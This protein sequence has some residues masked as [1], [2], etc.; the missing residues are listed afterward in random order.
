M[1]FKSRPSVSKRTGQTPFPFRAME[2]ECPCTAFPSKFYGLPYPEKLPEC[3]KTDHRFLSGAT[4]YTRESISI[5][6]V[7]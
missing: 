3:L 6:P 1:V 4:D 5:G 7:V 2:G